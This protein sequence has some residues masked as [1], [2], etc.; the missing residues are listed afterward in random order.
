MTEHEL[1]MCEWVTPP[2]L[3]WL[4]YSLVDKEINT[5]VKIDD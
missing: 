3:G 2:N 5:G 1:G 4:H